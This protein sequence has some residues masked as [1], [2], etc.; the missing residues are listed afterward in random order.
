ML[1]KSMAI[2]LREVI[3]SGGEFRLDSLRKV[4]GKVIVELDIIV[5]VKMS[6]KTLREEIV[7]RAP[8]NAQAYTRPAE[9]FRNGNLVTYRVKYLSEF[10][11]LELVD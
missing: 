7:K 2:N 1:S 8:P 9:L 4:S 10:R 11:E 6:Q 5:Y 3:E